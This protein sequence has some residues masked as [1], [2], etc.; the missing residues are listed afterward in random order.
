MMPCIVTQ[1]A[2]VVG[3]W[4]RLVFFSIVSSLKKYLCQ[5]QILMYVLSQLYICNQTCRGV[6]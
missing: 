6:H 4:R 3:Y 2:V 5:Y 1:L